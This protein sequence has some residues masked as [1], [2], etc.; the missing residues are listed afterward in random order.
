MDRRFD[1]A[2]LPTT[3]LDAVLALGIYDDK[4]NPD[5]IASGFLY[6]DYIRP[7][8]EGQNLYRVYL[9]TNRHVLENKDKICI[10]CNPIADEPAKTY[11]ARLTDANGER[12]WFASPRGDADV[13]VL[14]VNMP[15]LRKE[16]MKVSYFHSDGNVANAEKMKEL[17]MAEGDSAYALGF[18]MK[19]VGEQ[20]NVVIVRSG[21][22][23]RIRDT[24]SG[25]TTNFLVDAFVFPGNSGGPVVLKPESIAVG[26]AEPI[27]LAYLIGVVAGYVTYKDIAVS[28]QTKRPR[29]IFEENSGLTAVYPIDFV[30][31]AV[32]IAKRQDTEATI[33]AG[34]E[35]D[36]PAQ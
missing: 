19:L 25:S 8:E 23:A 10:R 22:I 35:Q 7:A 27:R 24:I 28:M 2:L 31:Q 9:V 30:E 12:L 6:G 17:G 3:Y 34:Q 14:S 32:Q 26:G 11:T 4:G 33:S 5:W 13:A 29:V 20:R 16:G 1:M 18:P 36:R 21:S 15:L